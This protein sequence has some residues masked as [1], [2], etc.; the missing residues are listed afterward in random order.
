M[1]DTLEKSGAHEGG[2]EEPRYILIWFFLAV[3][4]A[5]EVA[6]AEWGISHMGLSRTLI[7]WV[8]L[9]TA[10]WKAALVAMYYMHL[11]FERLRLVVLALSPLPLAFIFVFAVLT[12]YVW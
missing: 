10:I 8:L 4:T 11:R 3:L 12:E 2:H 7:I 1:S 5:L 9:I 6:A